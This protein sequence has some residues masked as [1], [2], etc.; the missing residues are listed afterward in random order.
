M[1]KAKRTPLIG[2]AKDIRITIRL[3]TQEYEQITQYAARCELSISAYIRETALKHRPKGKDLTRAI[4]QLSKHGG[5]LKHLH[6]EG[7][8]YSAETAALLSEI[9]KT[10]RLLAYMA[11]RNEDK[12][13]TDGVEAGDTQNTTEEKGRT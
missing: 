1:Q 9:S 8:G 7:L 4:N 2:G 10:I 12:E 5:L 13:E 11:R 6:N 3:T